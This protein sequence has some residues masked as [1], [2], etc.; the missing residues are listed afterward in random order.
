M[1]DIRKRTGKKGTTYQVRYPSTA[2]KSGYAYATFATRKAA[3]AYIQSGKI[4]QQQS[5]APRSDITT[6]TAATEK[7][8]RICEKEGLNGRE[9]I[10]RYTLKNYDYRAAFI[11]AYPWPKALQELTPPDIVAF[12][13]WLLD[14]RMSRVLAGKVMASLHSI[15]KEMTLRGVIPYNVASGVSIRAESRYAQPVTIPTRKE[16][17][18][19]LQA[20]DALA[21]SRN[22]SIAGAWQRYRPILYLA[23]D[24]GMRPQEYLAISNEAL[25]EHGVN[26][27]RAID[28][29]GHSLSVTKTAAGR[30]YIDLS[31]DVLDMVRHY[32]AHH[33]A[34]NR[35]DLVFPAENGKWLCRKNW[36]RRG[37]NVACL[38][39]GLTIKAEKKG[40][41]IEVPK[42]RPYDLR[43]FF[44]S[45]LI[46][47]KT[48][49]KKIQ[50]LMGHSNIET[51]LNVYGHLL[52][53]DDDKGAKGGLLGDLLPHGYAE[54]AE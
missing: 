43:H 23:V 15:F 20:A 37:F 48:N 12:R 5:T 2:T 27:L 4:N 28:G 26:V 17:V 44:A 25:D 36:Q 32:S 46:E 6:V 11:K 52:E 50:T 8:L 1:T 42:F 45:L 39:A 54:A 41:M 31:P 19:L 21:N 51:T 22:Q 10:T 30:R 16:I 24:S 47:K 3:L 38:E 34:A 14:G 29:S 35:Y 33:A 18:S 9:P 53:D 7:W 40:E 49:L 13:S